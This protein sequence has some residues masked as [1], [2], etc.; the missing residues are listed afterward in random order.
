MIIYSSLSQL[1]RADGS[2]KYSMTLLVIGA[3]INI[4]LD[5]IFIF[6]FHLGVKGGAYATIIGQIVSFVMAI[7]YLRKTKTVKLDRDS[8]KIDRSI[9]RTLGL[10]LSSFITQATVLA[11]FV[12]MNNMMTKIW[13]K[14]KIWC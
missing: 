8:F 6:G 3:I 10:G 1:I 4:I 2:P 7:L 13:C 14:Y 12:F 5:P 9:L 11:L